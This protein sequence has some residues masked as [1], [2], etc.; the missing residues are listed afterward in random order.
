M[1]M[2]FSAL[3]NFHLKSLIDSSSAH[4]KKISWLLACGLPPDRWRDT[5]PGRKYTSHDS[6]QSGLGFAR[7][8]YMV[9]RTCWLLIYQSCSRVKNVLPNDSQHQHLIC[10]PSKPSGDQPVRFQVAFGVDLWLTLFQLYSICSIPLIS[11][12]LWLQWVYE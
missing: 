2:R 11:I 12:F 10:W 7:G 6:V 8:A 3:L 4:F 1:E 9:K 5:S